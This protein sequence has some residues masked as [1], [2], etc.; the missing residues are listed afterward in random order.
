MEE[1]DE[2]QKVEGGG[3]GKNFKVAEEAMEEVYLLRSRG[4]G[5]EDLSDDSREGPRPMLTLS[6]LQ[7]GSR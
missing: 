6:Q 3:G 1:E 7:Q 4:V 5:W 2:Q